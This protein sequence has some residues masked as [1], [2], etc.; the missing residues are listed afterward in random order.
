MRESL[1]IEQFEP[2]WQALEDY[3]TYQRASKR[4]RQKQS[5]PKPV[6]ADEDFPALYRRLC[7]HLALAQTRHFSE[8]ITHRLNRLVISGHHFLYKKRGLNLSAFYRFLWLDFPSAVRREKVVMLWALATF[9]VPALVCFMIVQLFPTAAYSFIDAG[10]LSDIE[11]MYTP[12]EK[13]RLGLSR[14]S[15]SDVLM[16]GFYIFNNIGIA[17]RSFGSGLVL[18]IGSI[19]V[20][21]FNGMY[22]GVIFSHLQNAGFATQTLYPF[23]ITHGAFE[24]TAIV[25]SCGAGLKLGLSFLMPGR[26]RRIDSIVRTAQQLVP[27]IIGFVIMLLIAAFIEA[28]WSAIN[29]P[30]MIKYIVGTVCWV[31]VIAYF[32]VAGRGYEP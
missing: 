23:V 22:L 19:V 10:T 24:L 13:A 18:G 29:L 2:E 5:L 1:F 21:V 30:I 25:I 31:L 15:E 27:I 20:S 17:L 4:Q 16:F 32:G 9:V 14:D 26:Y 11:S 28:F 12:D 3:L 7:N 6:I 8:H